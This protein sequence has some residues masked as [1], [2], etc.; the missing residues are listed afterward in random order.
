V[1]G[2]ES[3]AAHIAMAAYWRDGIQNLLTSGKT[4]AYSI[5]FEGAGRQTMANKKILSGI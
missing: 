5:A 2:Y 1:A 3:N 4:Y